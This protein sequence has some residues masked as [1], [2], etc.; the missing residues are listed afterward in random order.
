MAVAAILPIQGVPDELLRALNDRFRQISSSTAAGS[1]GSPAGL[2]F[3]HKN[4]PD[5]NAQT[6]GTFG[7][8][9]DRGLVYQ[10]QTVSSAQKWVYCSGVLRAT[11][12]SRP[13]DLGAQDANLQWSVTDYGHLLRWT[14]TGWEFEDRSE[15]RRVGKECRSR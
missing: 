15:E 1:T 14:G 8:E 6:V 5:A 13:T 3:T 4:R 11:F 7:T 9:T 12:A 2:F 10:V